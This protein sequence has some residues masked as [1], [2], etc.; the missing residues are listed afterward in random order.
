MFFWNCLAFSMI[1]WMLI[2]DI[3]FSLSNFT[4][5][6]RD[7]RFIHINTNDPILFF[8]M[9]EWYFIVYMYHIFFIHSPVNER[10]GCFHVLAVVNSAAVKIGVHVSFWFSQVF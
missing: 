3:Y 1:Q 4:L 2:Y 7:S 8:F 10:L 9:A 6:D 5:Y